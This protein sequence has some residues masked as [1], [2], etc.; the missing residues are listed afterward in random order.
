[1]EPE[2]AQQV[3]D[4]IVA[5]IEK[6]GGSHSKWYCGI[7]SDWEDRLF[8]DHQVPR[9]NHWR[10]ALQCHNSQAARNVE[11]ELHKLGCDGGPGGGDEA[12]VYVYAYLKGNM[13]DP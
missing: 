11:D 3:Y 4:K 9:E 12:T 13:T 7:A 10:I 8:S 1:M 2:S 5:H 6:Q